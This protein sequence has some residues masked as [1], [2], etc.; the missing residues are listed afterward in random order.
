MQIR[1]SWTQ[2][3]AFEFTKVKLFKGLL[4]NLCWEKLFIC[5]FKML[6]VT[7]PW[8]GPWFSLDLWIVAI[9][10]FLSSV[11][12][13]HGK[14]LILQKLHWNQRLLSLKKCSHFSLLA[15]TVCPVLLIFPILPRNDLDILS[16]FPVIPLF[17]RSVDRAHGAE[18]RHSSPLS[19]EGCCTLVPSFSSWWL[20]SLLL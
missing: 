2:E 1:Y 8:M 4:S 10:S 19:D 6:W 20:C 13:C 18:G 16:L 12:N 17:Q 9:N 7:E 15:V 3:A 11:C 14:V 5:I